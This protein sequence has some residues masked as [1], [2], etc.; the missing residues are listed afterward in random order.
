MASVSYSLAVGDDYQPDEITVG[1]SA[2]GAG[3]VEVRIDLTKITTRLQV[4]LIMEA[5]QRRIDA[6][7]AVDLGIV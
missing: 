7:G 4:S 1:T 2:P 3:A 5:I 6:V